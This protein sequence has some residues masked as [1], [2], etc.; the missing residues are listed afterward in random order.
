[1]DAMTMIKSYNTNNPPSD[2]WTAGTSRR[3]TTDE[4]TVVDNYIA[5]A[6]D[7]TTSNTLN[8]SIK[9]GGK[10]GCEKMRENLCK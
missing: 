7:Y 6:L 4:C 9:R 8:H 1:M 5:Q 2:P 10:N 3:P